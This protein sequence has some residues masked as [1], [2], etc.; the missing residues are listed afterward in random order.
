MNREIRTSGDR[1]RMQRAP[2]CAVDHTPPQRTLFPECR[3]ADWGQSRRK[4]A[5]DHDAGSRQRVWCG[6]RARDPGLAA[7]MTSAAGLGLGDLARL[8]ATGGL[9]V[10]CGGLLPHPKDQANDHSVAQRLTRDE[11][12]DDDLLSVPC[13]PARGQLAPI[14]FRQRDARL[15]SRR[16]GFGSW[17]RAGRGDLLVNGRARL[18]GNCGWLRRRR[19]HLGHRRQGLLGR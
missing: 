1:N 15:P 6:I 4:P 9:P 8:L 12:G 16:R 2:P 14:L 5:P 7:R 3:E 18:L 13:V 10:R 17:R 19:G 11:H